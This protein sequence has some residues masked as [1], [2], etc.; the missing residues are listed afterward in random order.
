MDVPLLL[1]R[2]DDREIVF[3]TRANWSWILVGLGGLMVAVAL[4]GHGPGKL[5]VR[6]GVLAVA[7]VVAWLGLR[8]MLWRARL[9]LDL[10]NRRYRRDSG[11]I[12][13]IG[14][15]TGSLDEIEAVTLSTEIRGGGRSGTYTV[16]IVELRFRKPLA[17]VSIEGLGTEADARELIT[18]LTR[19]LHVS[20]LDRTVQPTR[21]VDWKDVATPL[22]GRPSRE[23]GR[24]IS[25]PGAIPPAPP[26]SGI[27]I[28]HTG[29][30]S[31]ITLPLP[32]LRADALLVI[33]FTSAFLWIGYLTLRGMVSAIRAGT[34]HYWL[35]WVIGSLLFL[36]GV[37]GV[38][39][40][41][42]LMLAREYVRDDG[43]T[44]VLGRRILGVAYG[45][46]RVAK[47]AVMDI[48][49]S[50]AQSA[51]GDSARVLWAMRDMVPSIGNWQVSVAILQEGGRRNLGVTLRS[52][53]Q[54]WLVGALR[55]MC[56]SRA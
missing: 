55:A 42:A 37:S 38:V 46:A 54:Q 43:D 16:W 44:L 25:S 18:L 10:I 4:A 32:G 40:G 11:Y 14:T 45:K 7:S 29:L 2:S 36:I 22:V 52:G 39:H 21:Q 51:E 6:V 20:F 8:A 24:D 33:A 34:E 27:E 19:T 23:G 28:S 41:V 15:Q 12:W 48:A 35:G 9:A 56:E 31:V 30:H 53:E 47:D 5:G 13:H 17:A 3:E 50:P 49:I 1:I 26:A